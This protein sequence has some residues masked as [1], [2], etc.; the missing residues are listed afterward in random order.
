MG[1]VNGER[2]FVPDLKALTAVASDSV[3][4]FARGND[5]FTVELVFSTPEIPP[6]KHPEEEEEEE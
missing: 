4:A 1:D 6:A 3:H 2:S 5:E